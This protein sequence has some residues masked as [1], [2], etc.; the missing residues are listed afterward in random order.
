[1]RVPNISAAPD[2]RTWRTASAPDEPP[3]SRVIEDIVAASTQRLRQAADLRGL[4]RP[5]AAFEAHEQSG[6][7]QQ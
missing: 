1:M 2:R 7:V 5:L 3:G 6:F 4:T